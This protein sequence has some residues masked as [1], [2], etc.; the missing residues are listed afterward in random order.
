MNHPT[1]FSTDVIESIVSNPA[2]LHARRELETKANVYFT[3]ELPESVKQ[4]LSHRIGLNILDRKDVPMRWIKGDTAPHVDSGEASFQNTYLVYLTSSPGSF[5]LDGTSYPIQAGEGYVFSEGLSHTTEGTQGIPRLL[6]GP[7]SEQGFPVGSPLNYYPTE[8]D[9]LAFTNMIASGGFDAFTVQTQGGYSSWRL[10]SNSTGSSSQLVVYVTGNTLNSDGNY[11]LYPA[12][13]CFLE[14]SSLC[15]LVDGK[16]AY[17]AIETLR[18][19]TLVKTSQHGYKT[20]ELI[21]KYTFSNTGTS[22]RTENKIYVCRKEK[23]PSLTDDLYITGAHS[24]LVKALSDTERD[25]TKKHLGK[26]FVTENTYRLMAWLD[27][28]AEPWESKGEYTLWHLALEN[29]DTGMNYG[30]YANGGLLVESAAIR[31]LRDRS[32]MELLE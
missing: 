19:G 15:C 11:Y 5:I 2:V 20:V 25:A 9:A 26:I 14:G 7:M 21:G 12:T 32:N 13:P 18:K 23:Y 3:M 30:I 8:T 31:S 28:K 1:V 16:E 27:E 6:L 29:T 17:V 24:I 10:A 4:I 22:D